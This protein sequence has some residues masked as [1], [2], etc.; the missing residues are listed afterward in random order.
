MMKL[1]C[2]EYVLSAELIALCVDNKDHVAQTLCCVFHD[3]FKKTLKAENA[4]EAL[5]LFRVEAPDIVFIDRLTAMRR[6][7]F[8]AV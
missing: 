7:R 3:T 4:Q 2:P 8:P 6:H 1:N 5:T